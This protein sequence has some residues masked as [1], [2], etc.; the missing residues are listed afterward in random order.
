MATCGEGE[1]RRFRNAL[2]SASR[3]HRNGM[4]PQMSPPR[5]DSH[6]QRALP[7]AALLLGWSP[8]AESRGYYVDSWRPD[9]SGD[10]K[11]PSTAWK[12]FAKFTGLRV[13]PGDTLYLERG[14]V[15]P[16]AQLI[17]YHGGSAQAPFV[18]TDHGDPSKPLPH[19]RSSHDVFAVGMGASHQVLE[20]LAVSAPNAMCI[21]SLGDSFSD[22]TIQELEISDCRGGIGLGNVDTALVRANRISRMRFG[23]K[24][25]GAIGITLD[26]TRHVRILEN[27]LRDCIDGT[28]DAEDGGAIELFRQNRDIE[29]A[30]NRA[31]NTAGFLEM[32]GLRSD[33]DS[34]VGIYVHHNIA[35]EVQNFAWSSVWTSKDTS[36]EWA[37]AFREVYFDHNTMIQDHR[38]GGLAIG[39]STALTDSTQMRIRDNLF[40]GDS[41]MGYLYQGPFS[42]GTNLF[43]SPAKGS[44]YPNPRIP[45]DLVIDP[46]LV[47]DT[48]GITYSL[49]TTSPARNAGRSFT[50][51][52][53]SIAKWVPVVSDGLPDLGALDASATALSPR[54]ATRQVL[55]AK[56]FEDRIEVAG[57]SAKETNPRFL[58]F[59]TNGRILACKPT[60]QAD[61]T[62]RLAFPAF[63]DDSP[64][65]LRIL[66]EGHLE[67]LALANA[68]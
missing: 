17:L 35:M 22:L 43:W 67:S 62:W 4:I 2:W 41:L 1:V 16:D 56:R 19:L 23:T 26:K 48:I 27:E 59:S 52:A 51:P 6:L 40:T 14:S 38:K 65:Y 61:G 39:V 32:G 50:Y 47:R 11:T 9:N 30:G 28:N 29:I 58:A 33:R 13:A 49:G 3:S 53:G 60:K 18:V 57:I 66:S 31:R 8:S 46:S 25:S 45:A 34:M 36:N 20:H 10:A 15:W 68:R 55:S 12:D 63:R 54:A 44:A 7:L 37:I 42:R 24:G 64:V 21:S 5:N